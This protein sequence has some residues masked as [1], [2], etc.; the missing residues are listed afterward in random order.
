MGAA[1]QVC[2]EQSQAENNEEQSQAENNNDKAVIVGKLFKDARLGKKLTIPEIATQTHI[3]QLYL[4]AIEEGNL[5]LLPGEIYKIGF[6]KTY[7]AFLGLDSK[8][9][10]RQ[11]ELNQEVQVSYADNKYI[12]P[13]DQQQRPNKKFLYLSLVGVLIFSAGVY[14]INFYDRIN[15]L[16]PTLSEGVTQK[17]LITST[18]GKQKDLIQPEIVDQSKEAISLEETTQTT[19]P[20]VASIST[21]TTVETKTEPLSITPSNENVISNTIPTS[22]IE[23]VLAAIKD[24][25]VQV[26]DSSDKTIYVRLMHA[27]DT[28]K[29]PEEGVFKLNTGNAGGLKVSFNGVESKILGTEGQVIRGIDLTELGLKSFF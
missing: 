18:A 3:R 12:V 5:N 10:L 1:T 24:T 25:W 6:I 26:L 19:V 2:E 28:Y 16:M 29:L 7:S 14:T 17:K 9:I 13:T 15:L 20:S 8:E 21:T 11:L 4:S 22:R 23:I 27:G